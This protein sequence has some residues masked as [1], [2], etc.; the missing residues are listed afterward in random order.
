MTTI[1]TD[2]QKKA[3]NDLIQYAIFRWESALV[4]AVTILLTFLLPRPFAWWPIFGWPLLGLIGLGAII[5]ASL[6]DAETNA[7]V[8][9][10]TFQEQ[11]NPR[12][13][14]DSE[15]RQKVENALEYQR[16]IETQIRSQREGIMRDRLETTA[17]QFTDWIGNVHQLAVRLDAYREDD[18]LVR[19]REILPVE[20]DKL[21]AR[22][23][24]EHNPMLQEQLEQTIS[25]KG[26]HWQS[27]RALEDRMK[28]ANL[29][30]DQSLTALATIYSQVQLID[31]QSVG[32]GRAERLQ[33]DISEQVNRLDDLV[34]SINEVYDYHTK[35]V[36]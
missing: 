18:L 14:K 4:L 29:Q 34:S 15:L 23:E 17:N 7:R 22:R 16:R 20:I 30:L 3:Q 24:Q 1:R 26:Q 13:I 19:E 36:G 12:E 25:A 33:E 10:D 6:T 8:L 35:G 5:Y 31:A 32:S 28:Q 11:F 27:L 9:L 2:L 21:T